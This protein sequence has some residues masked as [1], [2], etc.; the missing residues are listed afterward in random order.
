MNRFK[1]NAGRRNFLKMCG[2]SAVPFFMSANGLA[3]PF[4]FDNDPS[5]KEADKKPS[6]NFIFDDVF[7]SPTEYLQKLTEINAAHAIERDFYGSGG[8]VEELQLAFAKL[9]GKEKAIFLPTGTMANQ[10]AVKLL[11]KDNTKVIVPE[12]SHVYR[13]EADA[14]QAVHNKRLIP[15]GK[16]KAYFTLQDLK[17]TIAYYDAGEVFKS[18]LGT[19]TMENPIRRTDETYVPL[20]VIKEIAGYCKEKG[21]KMHLDGARLHIA[22]AYTGISVAEYAADFDTVYISLYKY[23]NAAHGAILCGEA[24]VIDKMEHQVKIYGGTTFQSWDAAAMALHYLNGIDDRWK[25]VVQQSDALVTELNK[26]P[27]V[28]ISKIENGTNIRHLVLDKNIDLK[29]LAGILY[30]DYNIWLGRADENGIIKFTVNESI[31][32]QKNE[33]IVNAWQKG[34]SLAKIN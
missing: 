22:S 28:K 9:T 23:L 6:V 26:L 21:Y 20:P 24:A 27:G 18:G 34:I 11:S 12:N 25:S 5:K 8:V 13:D 7:F 10:L 4:L 3:N 31:L 32:R 17:D 30:N 16:D 15:T 19:I 1:S 33:Y 2:L 29:K 14:A